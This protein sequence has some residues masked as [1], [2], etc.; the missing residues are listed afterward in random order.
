MNCFSLFL[1]ESI[2]K[3]TFFL[4]STVEREGKLKDENS[5]FT[6]FLV[7]KEI[8]K[9]YSVARLAIFDEVYQECYKHGLII[10]TELM[11][12]VLSTRAG[13]WPFC[14]QLWFCNTVWLI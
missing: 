12:T 1:Y 5:Q 4:S 3:Q 14:W 9:H 2:V 7:F 10:F 8:A 13:F 6:D 11:S